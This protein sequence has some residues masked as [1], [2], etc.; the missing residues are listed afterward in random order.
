M[1]P[2]KPKPPTF[3]DFIIVG[4]DDERIPT[5]EEEAAN[6]APTPTPTP[7]ENGRTIVLTSPARLGVRK[8]TLIGSAPWRNRF[9]RE[10][11]VLKWQSTCQ[12]CGAAFTQTTSGEVTTGE[13]C[14]AFRVTACPEHRQRGK[15]S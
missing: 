6:R 9:G 5:R 12:K 3:R 14:A 8:W 1:N 4:L 2:T 15:R 10:V 11:G 13:Q 7:I